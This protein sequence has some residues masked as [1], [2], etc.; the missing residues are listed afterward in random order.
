MRMNGSRVE[1]LPVVGPAR[2]RISRPLLDA[3]PAIVGPFGRAWLCDLDAMR[4]A[5]LIGAPQDA[6]LAHWI[7]EAPWS[8]Q[9]VHSYSLLLMHLR[10]M[11]GKG[12]VVKYLEGAT[13]EIHL[14]AIHPEADRAGMLRQPIDPQNW[15]APSVFAAQV[16]ES[17]DAAAHA[18]AARAVEL[19]CQGRV[20]P[21]PAHVRVWAELFGD[22]MLRC[23]TA[24][25]MGGKE[26][27]TSR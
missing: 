3:A 24:P 21:H 13:H 12:P 22:N 1:F 15:L 16:A 27:E 6:L 10:F 7:V 5:Q 2:A 23:I 26:K 9:V 8:S 25:P 19:V 18:R 11:I 20:S 4:R 14:H 17:D